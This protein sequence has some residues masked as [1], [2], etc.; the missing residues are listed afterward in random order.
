MSKQQGQKKTTMTMQTLVQNG[1]QNALII[2][3]IAGIIA[4]IASQP[5]ASPILQPAEEIAL[6][7]ENIE[8]TIPQETLDQSRTINDMI[9]R[10][11]NVGSDA[12]QDYALRLKDL[13]K[14]KPA[15]LSNW[16][17][18][19]AKTEI[20]KHQTALIAYMI[21]DSG[22]TSKNGISTEAAWFMKAM[23]EPGSNNAIIAQQVYSDM[24]VGLDT[25]ARKDLSQSSAPWIAATVTTLQLMDPATQGYQAI[26]VT[27]PSGFSGTPAQIAQKLEQ[28]ATT[29]QAQIEEAKRITLLDAEIKPSATVLSIVQTHGWGDPGLQ[30]EQAVNQA[31]KS[32]QIPPALTAPVPFGGVTFS[33]TPV[34]WSARMLW[35][36]LLYQQVGPSSEGWYIL[37]TNQFGE[38]TLFGRHLYFYNVLL[39]Q[40][41]DTLAK[42]KESYGILSLYT[43]DMQVSKGQGWGTDAAG[44]SW[45]Q[46]QTVSTQSPFPVALGQRTNTLNIQ[47]LMTQGLS[48][49]QDK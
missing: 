36:Y 13:I 24:I 34:V 3:I 41:P 18:P 35:D 49:L 7:A 48:Y 5:K 15:L 22:E 29:Y 40:T 9:A 20:G 45:W 37:H 47:T 31:T 14:K 26:V 32:S 11:A 10:A 4:A 23:N 33:F 17:A 12:S 30:L 1:A 2:V 46:F 19:A 8:I 44:K 6:E 43:L 39:G 21:G 27:L 25:G 42:E 28:D 38:L 16:A